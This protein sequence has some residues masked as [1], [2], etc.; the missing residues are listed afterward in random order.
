MCGIKKDILI[1][2]L[3][4]QVGKL[5]LDELVSYI[6]DSD[7]LLKNTGLLCLLRYKVTQT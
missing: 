3:Q 5:L 4:D 2:R 6:I 7:F 1:S